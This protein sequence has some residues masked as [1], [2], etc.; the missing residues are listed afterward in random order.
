MNIKNTFGGGESRFVVKLEI[1]FEI[2]VEM[3]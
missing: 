3:W 1:V 2:K